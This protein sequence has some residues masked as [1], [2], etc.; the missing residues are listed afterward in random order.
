MFDDNDIWLIK[1]LWFRNWHH[2]A[3]EPFAYTTSH[4]N[5]PKTRG[6]QFDTIEALSHLTRLEL[7]VV[8]ERVTALINSGFLNEDM[9]LNQPDLLLDALIDQH[10]KTLTVRY[11]RLQNDDKETRWWSCFLLSKKRSWPFG[12]L[13]AVCTRIQ[14]NWMDYPNAHA[15]IHFDNL[16]EHI[17]IQARPVLYDISSIQY[18]GITKPKEHSYGW[19]KMM[20][21]QQ[22]SL[23]DGTD[24]H[25]AIVR[26]GPWMQSILH[27]TSHSRGAP[28]VDLLQAYMDLEVLDAHMIAEG[29]RQDIRRF[30]VSGIETAP[31]SH[32]QQ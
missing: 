6:I 32:D 25:L 26:S 16:S 21:D 7:D 20:K 14:R 2:S 8:K 3:F 12:G 23:C 11:F 28:T 5:E 18:A 30:L 19:E 29:L 27:G 22:W 1:H 9:T 10:R 15:F 17:D 31:G 13:N 4:G 24:A